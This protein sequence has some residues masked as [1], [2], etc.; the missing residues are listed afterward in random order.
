MHSL[1]LCMLWKA[2]ARWVSTSASSASTCNL[3]LLAF[4]GGEDGFDTT[5]GLESTNKKMQKGNV[6]NTLSQHARCQTAKRA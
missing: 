1:G 3:N 4:K 5:Q 6:Q 2:N